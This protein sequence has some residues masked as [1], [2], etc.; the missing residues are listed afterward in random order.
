MW[1][2]LIRNKY[3]DSKVISPVHYKHGRSNFWDRRVSECVSFFLDRREYILFDL[4]YTYKCRL[5]VS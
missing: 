4:G 1:E 3:I 5:I 2:D